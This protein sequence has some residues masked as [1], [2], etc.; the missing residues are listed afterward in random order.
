MM[1]PLLTFASGVIAGALGVRMVKNAKAK[2]DSKIADLR[3]ANL[4]AADVKAAAREGAGKAQTAVREAAVSGLLAIERTSAG[5]RTRLATPVEEAPVAAAPAE[6][7]TVKE[8]AAEPVKTEPTPPASP[9]G[10]A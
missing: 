3:A 2:A 4:K 5:L 1:L 9:S 8:N 6:A 7:E 10:A